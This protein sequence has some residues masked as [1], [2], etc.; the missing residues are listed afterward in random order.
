MWEAVSEG[1]REGVCEGGSVGRSE[2][3]WEERS[4]RVRAAGRKEEQDGAR[5]AYRTTHAM[6]THEIV[7]THAS[8]S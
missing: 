5:S 1:G 3:V 6:T 4:E 8:T 7:C 2:G